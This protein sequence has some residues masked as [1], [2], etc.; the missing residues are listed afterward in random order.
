[1]EHQLQNIYTKAENRIY[2]NK[3][4]CPRSLAVPIAEPQGIVTKIIH[5]DVLSPCWPCIKSK[6]F[7]PLKNYIL[8]VLVMTPCIQNQ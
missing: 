1:L 7:T 8:V 3:E 4:K 5:H 6:V 2:C